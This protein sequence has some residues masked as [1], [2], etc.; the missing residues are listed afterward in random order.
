MLYYWEHGTWELP[1]TRLSL[2]TTP[3]N[4]ERRK[5][6]AELAKQLAEE[7]EPIKILAEV[8]PEEQAEMD[9]YT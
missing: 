3:A 7:F 5:E 2:V 9:S 1:V 8:T 6:I 4:Q